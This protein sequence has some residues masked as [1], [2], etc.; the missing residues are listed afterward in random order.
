[1]GFGLK[2]KH[3]LPAVTPVSIEECQLHKELLPFTVS[4]SLKLVIFSTL[5][6]SFR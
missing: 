1:M 4:C 3:F 2:I 5:L 6:S